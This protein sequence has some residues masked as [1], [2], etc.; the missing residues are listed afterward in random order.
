MIFLYSV[1]KSCA[2]NSF[3]FKLTVHCNYTSYFNVSSVIKNRTAFCQ[4]HSFI[5]ASSFYNYITTNDFFYLC[6][7]SIYNYIIRL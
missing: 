6:I 3:S 7:R 5:N 1:L 2:I 4:F